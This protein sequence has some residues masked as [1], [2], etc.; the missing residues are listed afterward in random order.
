LGSGARDRRSRHL[1]SDLVREPRPQPT[2]RG[3]LRSRLPSQVLAHQVANSSVQGPTPWHNTHRRTLSR[4]GK[5]RFPCPEVV[6]WV[7]G[8]QWQRTEEP[9]LEQRP[10]SRAV[11][12]TD[13]TRS[14]VFTTPEAKPTRSSGGYLGPRAQDLHNTHRTTL[15][16]VSK[17]RFPTNPEVVLWDCR[18]PGT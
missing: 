13:L 11:T 6:L 2:W 9:P 17:G 16:R 5:G 3:Q 4:V 8:F 14:F 7:V 15:S 10:G 12:A 18:G 1:S